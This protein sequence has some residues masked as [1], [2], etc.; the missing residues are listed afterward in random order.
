MRY[1]VESDSNKIVLSPAELTFLWRSLR[2][3]DKK[4]SRFYLTAKMHKTPWATRPV[5]STC[6]TMMAGLSKWI[7]HWLQQLRSHVH[8]Y[9]QDSGHLIRLLKELGQLPPGAKLFVADAVGMY[10]NISTSHGITVINDWIDDYS[11]ELPLDFPV[12]AVK[13]ALKLVMNNNIFEFGDSF[14]EQI[15][16]CAMGTP[17]ACIYAT[18]YYAY[19][20][21]T[22]LLVKYKDNLPLMRRFI[23]DIFG[24]WVPSGNPNAWEEFERDLPFGILQWDLEKLTTTVNFLDLSISINANRHIET[25]TYQKAMN[26]YLYLPPQSAHP[27]SVIRGMS[28]GL[29]RKYR[30]QNTYQDHY[31]EMTV[32]LYQ[33][34]R[35]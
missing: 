29:I 16:G 12:A 7:D 5:V 9:L 6:G 17:V 15:S 33:R 18:L 28:C 26:L 2:K 24:I 4:L 25:R 11:D 19:H 10:T 13:D 23:D 27:P 30:E 31:I 3:S 21:R 32:L 20:E 22:T 8:T 14:F 34:L 35:E 1:S